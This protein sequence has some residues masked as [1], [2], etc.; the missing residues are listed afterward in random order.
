ML[1]HT[2]VQQTST[3][4]NATLGGLHDSLRRMEASRRGYEDV[5]KKEPTDPRPVRNEQPM[6]TGKFLMRMRWMETNVVK[7]RLASFTTWRA[8]TGR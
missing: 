6:A 3:Y 4:L 1:G 5:A 7:E 2:N 8:A